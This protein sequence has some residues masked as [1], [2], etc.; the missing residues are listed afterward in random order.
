SFYGFVADVAREQRGPILA[1]RPEYAYFH[2]GQPVEMEGSALAHLAEARAPGTELVLK[3]LEEARYSLLIWTWPLPETGGYREAAARSYAAAG[4]C[5]LG[6]YFGT[7]TAT[8]LPRRD[9]FRPML[10]QAGTRCGT[11]VPSL[12]PTT[13]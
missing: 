1:V 2:V 8:L 5:K 11:S 4:G 6:Y 9:L 3:R 10:P 12:V 7:V 13:D